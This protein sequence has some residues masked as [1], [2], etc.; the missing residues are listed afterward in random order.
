MDRL[1][2]F[3]KKT[4]IDYSVELMRSLDPNMTLLTT[5]RGDCKSTSTARRV[6]VST[7][8]DDEDGRE[9]SDV[10]DFRLMPRHEPAG[11]R[12]SAATQCD[13][14]APAARSARRSVVVGET[15]SRECVGFAAHVHSRRT[16]NDDYM[17][18]DGQYVTTN[19][20]IGYKQDDDYV[21]THVIDLTSQY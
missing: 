7:M 6:T 1:L 13:A 17:S 5:T 12:R 4:F 21:Q 14:A 18:Y 15:G 3:R 2:I 16:S 10:V 11:Q 8:T 9:D 19:D 20:V